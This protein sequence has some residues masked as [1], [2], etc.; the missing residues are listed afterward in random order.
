MKRVI[1]VLLILLLLFS[2]YGCAGS[3]RDLEVPASF[4][5]RAD[6]V[7][8]NTPTSIFSAEVRETADLNNNTLEIL[9]R[10]VAGPASVGYLS[11]FPAGV[12]VDSI[13]RDGERVIITM[14]D[15]FGTLTGVGLTAAC[16]CVTLTVTELIG[17]QEVVIQCESVSLDGATSIAMN[18]ANLH[19]MDTT[20]ITPQVS[21]QQ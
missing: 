5:Y 15:A 3:N 6:P 16:T 18:I 4:Y 12:S 7:T 1:S 9:N 14:N 8:Y 19:F 10:Y 11:P 2:A 21:E 17:C 13:K 20:D